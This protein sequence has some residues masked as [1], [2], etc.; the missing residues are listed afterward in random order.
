MN[1]DIYTDN[2][3]HPSGFYGI[4]FIAYERRDGR[5]DLFV[6]EAQ[7]AC[8]E[9]EEGRIDEQHIFLK[10]LEG[11]NQIDV[12]A[13]EVMASLGDSY[14]AIVYYRETDGRRVIDRLCEHFKCHRTGFYC[15]QARN[16]WEFVIRRK[17]GP[18]A[19]EITPSNV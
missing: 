4:E 9:L 11:P 7:G 5:W 14:D 1:W 18:L 17:D 15:I 12:V 2:H 19:E 13:A 3:A 8:P 16:V 6:R 10:S